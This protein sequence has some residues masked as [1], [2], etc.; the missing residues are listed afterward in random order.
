MEVSRVVEDLAG[1][2]RGR[3][4]KVLW[5]DPGRYH[6]RKDCYIWIQKSVKLSGTLPGILAFCVLSAWEW[7]S[8][9]LG[10]HLLLKP[11]EILALVLTY[12]FT[13]SL[14]I[15][16][17]SA[18]SLLWVSGRQWGRVRVRPHPLP[19]KDGLVPSRG[20]RVGPYVICA[21]PP[22]TWNSSH[23][24]TV[25]LFGH[26]FVLLSAF[27]HFIL[28]TSFVAC[29]SKCWACRDMDSVLF[30]IAVTRRKN[31]KGHM[32]IH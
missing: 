29:S 11:I 3:K 23:T 10:T 8:L 9:T 28:V 12:G 19:G 15:S 7:V 32:Y 24:V 6:I 26:E 17:P 14:V 2:Y 20:P 16:I 25:W 27:I 5:A 21:M 22:P 13:L 31:P 30:S 1:F 18:I 4:H